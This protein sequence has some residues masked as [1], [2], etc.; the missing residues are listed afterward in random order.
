MQARDK[1]RDFAITGYGYFS[2]AYD[3]HVRSTFTR[4]DL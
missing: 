4:H 2:N 1:L 3:F